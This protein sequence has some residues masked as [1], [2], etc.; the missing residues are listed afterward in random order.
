MFIYFLYFIK[1]RNIRPGCYTGLEPKSSQ[2]HQVFST[3]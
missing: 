3:T 2:H 1:I